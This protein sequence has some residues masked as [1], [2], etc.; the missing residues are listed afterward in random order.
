MLRESIRMDQGSRLG[1]E[2]RLLMDELVY[3]M[4]SQNTKRR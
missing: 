2:E 4:R 1:D 3:F